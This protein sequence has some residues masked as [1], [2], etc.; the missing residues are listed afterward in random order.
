MPRQNR[1]AQFAPFDALKGLSDALRLK[2]YQHER[3]A[4]GDLQEEKIIEISNIL[5]DLKKDDMVEVTYFIDGYYKT[6]HGKS[7]VDIYEQIIKVGNYKIDFTNIFDI[8][9]IN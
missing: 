4:K 7:K 9:K 8:K 2:E 5:Q 6:V 3:L 1:A